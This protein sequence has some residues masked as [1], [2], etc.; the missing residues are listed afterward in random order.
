MKICFITDTNHPNT[1]NWANYFA[2]DL[3]HDVHILSLNEPR[4]HNYSLK[5][6]QI[7]SPVNHKAKYLLAHKIFTR[8]VKKIN[9]NLL[10]GYRLT[11]YAYI[12]AKTGFHPFVAVAQSEKAGGEYRIIT[13]PL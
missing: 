9:P 7:P 6:H 11:S 12:A 8:Y 2:T 3:G 10:I 5:V 1:L 13:K 4:M